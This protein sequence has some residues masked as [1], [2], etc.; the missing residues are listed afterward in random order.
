MPVTATYIE[1][2]TAKHFAKKFYY[3]VLCGERNWL[4][5]RERNNPTTGEYSFTDTPISSDEAFPDIARGEI[6]KKKF[7]SPREKVKL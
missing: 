1:Y 3:H 7:G 6:A 4:L 5:E 2:K